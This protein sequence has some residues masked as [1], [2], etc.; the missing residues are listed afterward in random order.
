MWLYVVIK[1][2]AWA[3]MVMPLALRY[4]VSTVISDLLWLTWTSK[5]RTCIDN[6]SVVMEKSATDPDVRRLARSAFHQFGKGIV[7]FLGFTNLDPDDPVVT[8]ICLEGWDN[9]KAG[10]ARGKG[11]ILATAHFG[12]TDMGGITLANRSDF[13]AVADVFYP[14][15]VD[16]LIRRTR[17]SKGYRLIPATSARGIIRALHANALVV[18]LFDRPMEA[19][20][21]VPVSFFGRETAL[22]AGVGMVARHS[23]ATVVPGYIFRNPDNSFRGKIY[24]SVSEDLTGDKHRDVQTVMQRLADSLEAAVR[25]APDQWYMFRPMWPEAV[26]E[27]EPAR[28][29]HKAAAG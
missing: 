17:E 19:G 13:Y 4:R 11:V 25:E 14:P 5:R 9:V 22:P 8:A 24:E 23:G 10:L 28:G 16:R 3:S 26:R 2:G 20:E 1:A 15:Y 21:G 6:Y 12:S 27:A 29:L 18:V 7:D